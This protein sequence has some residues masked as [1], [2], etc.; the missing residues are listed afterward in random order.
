MDNNFNIKIKDENF[1]LVW[2]FLSVGAR[3]HANKA[4]YKNYFSKL[5]LSILDG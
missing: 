5:F 4:R 2:K 1:D 3:V